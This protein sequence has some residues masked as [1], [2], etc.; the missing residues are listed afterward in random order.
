[1][2]N[3]ITEAEMENTVEK[4]NSGLDKAEDWINDLEDS[5]VESNKNKKKKSKG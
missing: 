3:T 1:M 4:I 5:V 2:K